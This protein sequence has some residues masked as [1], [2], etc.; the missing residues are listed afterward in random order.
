MSN[1]SANTPFD[2]SKAFVGMDTSFNAGGKRNENLWDKAV[3]SGFN[4]TPNLS[5]TSFTPSYER[6]SATTPTQDY[7]SQARQLAALESELTP[8][9]LTRA[10][11]FADLQSELS[12]KQLAQLYPYLTAARSRATA[13][14]LAASQAY[15]RFAEQLPS[16]VQNIMASKQQQIQSAQAGEAALQQ[17]TADQLRAAKESQGRF[18]GQYVQFG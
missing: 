16:N 12:A 17:A 10:K 11:A 9:V 15:R 5:S 14:D 8:T 18:A 4:F 6:T 1:S 7:L 13:E 3:K 2:L